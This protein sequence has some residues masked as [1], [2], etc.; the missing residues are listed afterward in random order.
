MIFDNFYSKNYH[1]LICLKIFYVY[2]QLYDTNGNPIEGA[3]VDVNGD[4]Q[5][6]EADR[7]AYKK[8]TP[9]AFIGLT[10]NFSYKNFDMS[11]TFRGSFGNYMYNNVA[12]DRGNF[13][14]VIDAPGNYY[15]NAHSSVLSTNFNEQRLFSDHYIQN[16]DF[17]KLDNI[18]LGYL[19]PGEKVDF[20]ASFTAT[21]VFV[22]TEYSGLDPEVFNGIDNTTARQNAFDTIVEVLAQDAAYVSY[23]QPLFLIDP[24]T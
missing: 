16:A 18:S 14:T 3:Y 24:A 1:K 8:A 2:H 5:I 23:G 17:I 22:I 9:D 19:I 21:N 6:T 4:N 11:F 12:S 13:E 10:N 15:P 20:R 7:Q